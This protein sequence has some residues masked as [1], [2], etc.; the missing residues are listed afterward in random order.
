MQKKLENYRFFAEAAK[1]AGFDEDERKLAAME[2][3]LLLEGTS[4]EL[5]ERLSPEALVSFFD[6]L[7][8]EKDADH[9]HILEISNFLYNFRPD[10]RGRD[11]GD[12]KSV[13]NEKENRLVSLACHLTEDA[14]Y[15]GKLENLTNEQTAALAFMLNVTTKLCPE[16]PNAQEWFDR[17]RLQEFAAEV[18]NFETKELLSTF[19]ADGQSTA[20]K[21]GKYKK[22]FQASKKA[23]LERMRNPDIVPYFI[24]TYLIANSMIKNRRAGENAEE[25]MQLLDQ[26][27]SDASYN[28]A[29]KTGEYPSYDLLKGKNYPPIKRR[30]AS[31]HKGYFILHYMPEK[32]PFTFWTVKYLQ[33]KREKR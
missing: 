12:E 28:I 23:V 6:A 31:V 30:S 11:A 20:K 3:E 18:G 16:N 17:D 10:Q 13:L 7:R 27:C 9:R 24:K 29:Q 1:K 22:A 32:M 26:W 8:G 15:D 4:E 25:E 2:P 21:Q 14:F 19:A 33:S 5:R